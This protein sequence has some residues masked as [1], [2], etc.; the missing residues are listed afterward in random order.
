MC[1][2]IKVV[3]NGIAYSADFG[4]LISDIIK[5]EKPCGGHGRCGKCKVIVAGEVSEPSDEEKRQLSTDELENGVR[6]SCK[7]RALGDCE[8]TT[9]SSVE[10]TRIVTDG[11]LPSFEIAP[12]FERFG[13]AIDVGTT[14]IASKLYDTRG[15]VLGETACLNPQKEWGAD[16]I[17][18]I[19]SALGGRAVELTR[20]IRCAIDKIIYELSDKANISSKD[21]DGAVITGNTVMLSLLAGESVEPFSYAP[22][23][24]ERLFGESI[25]VKKL[26][27][28]SLA[29]E[30]EVYFP[31][32]ISAFVG[33]DTVCAVIAAGMCQNSVAM[34]ADIG[35]NGEIALWR[36]SRLSVC[37]TAAGPAFEGV[38]ISMGMRASSGAIDKVSIVNQRLCSHVIGGGLPLGICGSGLI[39]AVAC[40]LDLE[41]LDESGSLEEENIVV[42]GTVCVSQNDIRMLQLAKGAVC[43]GMLTLIEAE[44]T[45]PSDIQRLYIAGGFGSYLNKSSATRIGLIPKELSEKMQVVGNAALGGAAMLLLNEK[46]RNNAFDLARKATTVELATSSVFVEKY[47]TS[48]FLKKI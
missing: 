5:S 7:A 34:L 27:L 36:N 13:V 24:A 45:N 14:T 37:S 47:M 16:V 6:L 4:T 48:M 11:I 41:M 12:S 42:G 35:T 44:N 15:N 28:S 18:R 38:G 46:E 9:L 2:K 21:I 39:D 26:E 10:N 19:E 29:A 3:V 25:L 23:K 30:T 32:C 33:A 8:I 31:P 20:V 43:A 17:S 22:F 1:D 40:M